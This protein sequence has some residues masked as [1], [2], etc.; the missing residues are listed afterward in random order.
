MWLYDDDTIEH[1]IF[2]YDLGHRPIN[3]HIID[4]DVLLHGGT[5]EGEDP[6]R[7][8][9]FERVEA[10]IS[11]LGKSEERTYLLEQFKKFRHE[12]S[13]PKMSVVRNN[14]SVE[15]MNKNILEENRLISAVQWY[16]K[17]IKNNNFKGHHVVGE[18]TGGP[19]LGWEKHED[20]NTCNW[21]RRCIV[22][23]QKNTKE[24][25]RQVDVSVQ[26]EP[27]S[28]NIVAGSIDG[29]GMDAAHTFDTGTH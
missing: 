29:L 23:D 1:K 7:P 19:T 16:N 28:P 20:E 18:M 11:K 5:K 13:D 6:F 14:A 10:F 22:E 3:V 25:F 17:Q 8:E 26:F 24:P 15:E 27:N 4:F 9:N 2:N 21:V 12:F